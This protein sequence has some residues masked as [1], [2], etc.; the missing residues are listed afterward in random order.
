MI[1]KKKEVKK[2]YN[3]CHDY[4]SVLA[5]EFPTYEQVEKAR[6]E[7]R[8]DIMDTGKTGYLHIEG[9]NACRIYF[10]VD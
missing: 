5:G 2:C 4:G 1:F 10:E 3:A 6:K 8:I 9:E 7:N